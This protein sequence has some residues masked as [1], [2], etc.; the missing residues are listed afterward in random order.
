ML[1]VT[2]CTNNKPARAIFVQTVFSQDNERSGGGG[3]S[4]L[5][6]WIGELADDLMWIG[7]LGDGN[8]IRCLP[9]HNRPKGEIRGWSELPNLI[10]LVPDLLNLACPSDAGNVIMRTTDA[11]FV[12][13]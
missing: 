10:A 4:L 5:E 12:A 8:D 7:M 13:L 6:R 3:G 2:H 1:P 11:L 9:N